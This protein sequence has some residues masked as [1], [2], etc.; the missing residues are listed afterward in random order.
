MVVDILT[1]HLQQTKISDGNI[2][3]IEPLPTNAVIAKH[4]YHNKLPFAL[5]APRN[6]TSAGVTEVESAT[7]R[8]K[9]GRIRTSPLY[10]SDKSDATDIEMDTDGSLYAAPH[11]RSLLTAHASRRGGDINTNK[12]V[13]QDTSDQL[14][15]LLG[16]D[17]NSPASHSQ[18]ALVNHNNTTKFGLREIIPITIWYS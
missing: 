18:T 6:N 12:Q 1:L 14:N 17:L 5:F 8:D 7:T 13:N 3:A 2:S 4:K 11:I 10:L 16:N 15:I 9:N